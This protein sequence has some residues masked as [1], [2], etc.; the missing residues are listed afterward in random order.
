MDFTTTSNYDRDR[1]LRNAHF[2]MLDA[3]D[4]LR[5]AAQTALRRD[6][7]EG[8]EIHDRIYSLINPAQQLANDWYD[9]HINAPAAAALAADCVE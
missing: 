1:E 6:T 3:L 8:I 4:V 2:A 5:K 7:D 9:R